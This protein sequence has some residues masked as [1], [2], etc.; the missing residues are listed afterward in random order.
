MRLRQNISLI[1]WVATL[2]GALLLFAWV[3]VEA[4]KKY[5]HFLAAVDKSHQSI[6]T[7]R[8]QNGQLIAQNRVLQLQ[9][10][11]LA[12][13]LPELHEEIT[14]LQVK[15]SRTESVS[16][17]AF[18]AS[19]NAVVTVRDSV[20]YDTTHIKVFDF[21]DG[22]F[23]IHGELVGEE[24]KL[25]LSYQ[26]TLVQVVYRGE[27]EHPWLWIFSPRK[28]MQRVSLKNPNSSI[29]YSQNIQIQ[30]RK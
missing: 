18:T 22:F 16:Q 17:T 13:F 28:L 29:Y 14:N 1:L 5:K 6:K 3:K 24:Q 15:L 27:R 25:H 19:G 10:K 30:K 11:E 4:Q 2:L 8:A 21:E 23:D 26:D 20:L 12:A 7:L 9:T